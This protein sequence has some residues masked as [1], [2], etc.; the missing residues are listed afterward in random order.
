ME[1]DIEVTSL[2][3]GEIGKELKKKNGKL[4][5]SEAGYQSFPNT[6]IIDAHM[7]LWNSPVLDSEKSFHVQRGS[8]RNNNENW[9]TDWERDRDYLLKPIPSPTGEPR[10]DS[11]RELF[12]SLVIGS[13]E[14]EIGFQSVVGRGIFADNGITLYIPKSASIE[15]AFRKGLS[16]IVR[17]IN[18]TINREKLQQKA[19]SRKDEEKIIQYALADYTGGKIFQGNVRAGLEADALLV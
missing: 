4:L 7:G 6:Y 14:F 11:C 8:V 18:L 16:H 2:N 5:I 12:N 9:Q 3:I 17:K 13:Y 19:F 1:K 15:F 10:W